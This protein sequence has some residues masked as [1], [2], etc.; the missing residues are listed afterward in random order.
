MNKKQKIEKVVKDFC[1]ENKAIV[2]DWITL[3]ELKEVLIGI[4]PQEDEKK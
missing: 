2:G 3:A 4:S 1:K